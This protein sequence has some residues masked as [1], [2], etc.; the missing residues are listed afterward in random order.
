MFSKT[1]SLP[2]LRK[3]LH[4]LPGGKQ[5]AQR[6][7]D[8]EDAPMP[9][10][11]P[12]SADAGISLCPERHAHGGR[13]FDR[14][15]A[16]RPWNERWNAGIYLINDSLHPSHREYFTQGS[17]FAQ[18]PSQQWRRNLDLEVKPGVWRASDVERPPRFPP[19]GA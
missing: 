4:K 1:K 19:I 12:L 16:E 9:A 13:M 5:L 2:E 11:S 18:A 6:M 14:D 15:G 8:M 7:I 17:L 3:D 10:P